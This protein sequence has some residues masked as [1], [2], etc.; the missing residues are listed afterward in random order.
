MCLA[1]V[2][3]DGRPCTLNNLYSIS[4]KFT[5]GSGCLTASILTL[6][7]GVKTLKC[8]IKLGHIV[9]KGQASKPRG[10]TALSDD[11]IARLLVCYHQLRGLVYV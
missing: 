5:Y 4:L 3:V 7:D 1:D 6:E 2:L 9:L 11:S 8:S 10:K